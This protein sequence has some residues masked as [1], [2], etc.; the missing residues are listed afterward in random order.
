LISEF[1]N[2]VKIGVWLGSAVTDIGLTQ[3]LLQAMSVN[4]PLPSNVH[5]AVSS[6]VVVKLVNSE[7]M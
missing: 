7:T 6:G 4:G 3:W 1:R 2:Q 5:T